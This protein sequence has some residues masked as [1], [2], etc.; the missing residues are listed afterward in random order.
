MSITRKQYYSFFI[1]WFGF[2]VL[3]SLYS[4]AGDCIFIFSRA[5]ENPNYLILYL[6]QNFLSRIYLFPPLVYFYLYVSRNNKPLILRI[7]FVAFLTVL[8]ALWLSPEDWSMYIGEYRKAKQASA[9]LLA[10]LTLVIFEQ[11]VDRKKG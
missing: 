7:V 11:L 8:A 5:I 9:Y 3:E 2:C 6:L 4:Y 1:G 10:G